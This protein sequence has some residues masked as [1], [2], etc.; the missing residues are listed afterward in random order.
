M[1]LKPFEI[2]LEAYRKIGREGVE[3]YRQQAEEEAAQAEALARALEESERR[4]AELEARPWW[5]KAIDIVLPGEQFRTPAVPATPSLPEAPSLP[6]VS[7]PALTEEPKSWYTRLDERLGGILPFGQSLHEAVKKYQLDLST[8]EG[9]AELQRRLRIEGPALPAEELK[10]IAE[11]KSVVDVLG[12]TG[13]GPAARAA[14]PLVTKAARPVTGAVQKAAEVFRALP[15]P[16][17]TAAK[18]AGGIGAGVTAEEVI[19]GVVTP[20]AK[21]QTLPAKLGASLRAGF[22]DVL[23]L[24]GSVAKMLKQESIGEKLQR[25]GEAV[26]TGFEAQPVEF[27]WKSFFDPDWYA[28]NVARAIPLTLS[29][30]PAMYLGYKTGGAAGAKI[31][32]G[33]FGRAILG[34]LVGAAASRPLES[35]FE[36]ADTYETYLQKNPGDIAGAEKAARN[37]FIKNLPLGVLDLSELATAF[38]PVQLKPLS[39]IGKTLFKATGPKLSKVLKVAGRAIGA[40]PQE[41]LEEG[42]Q[43]VIQRQ[44][45]GEPVTFDTKMKEAMAIGGLFGAGMGGVEVSSITSGTGRSTN[46]PPR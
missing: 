27:S 28:V 40:A 39:K 45:L 14:A 33:P 36:A 31:G 22:G 11:T 9:A 29:L 15:K 43:E 34:S 26:R 24:T 10:K 13:L 32:L 37:T 4:K 8:P 46:F 5:Q 3:K 44:S 23:S 35:A 6:P 20:K 19:R 21:E 16:T 12:L 38:T 1:P 25:A 41:A 17:Q 18:I 7:P 42:I 2:D 30:I